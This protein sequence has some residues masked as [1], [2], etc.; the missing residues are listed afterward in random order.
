[1]RIIA[2]LE[3]RKLRVIS[4]VSPSDAALSYA[5]HIVD[6]VAVLVYGILGDRTARTPRNTATSYRREV[7]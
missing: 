4:P 7:Q 6:V 1:M 3:T 5:I 2:G